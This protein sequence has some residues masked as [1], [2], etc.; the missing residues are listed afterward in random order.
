MKSRIKIV[1][2]MLLLS[3]MVVLAE[4]DTLEIHKTVSRVPRS[5]SKN[6]YVLANYL[7]KKYED[8]ESKSYAISNWIANNIKYDYKG[9]INH[10]TQQYSS[11]KVLKKRKA[12]CGEYS[13][14]YK[15]MCESVEIQAIT[16]SGYTK[17]LDFLAKDTIYISD[18]SWNIS[19]IND[20]L[21]L[22]DHTFAS[23]AIQPR[24]QLLKN[25][26]LGLVG[27]PYKPK[28]YFKQQFNPDWINVVPNKMILTHFPDLSM[29]QLLQN[30]V[31]VYDFS[32]EITIEESMPISDNLSIKNYIEM[33]F[34]IKMIYSA[35]KV[36]ETNQL[37]NKMAGYYY[38]MCVDYFFKNHY[39]S[40]TKTFDTSVDELLQ[41]NKYAFFADSLLK[42]TLI[43]NDANYQQKKLQNQQMRNVLKTNNKAF[44]DT[45][46]KR[47]RKNKENINISDKIQKKSKQIENYCKIQ[48]NKF[49][50]LKPLE[51]TKRP[52]SSKYTD[53]EKTNVFLSKLDSIQNK[54]I[55]AQLSKIDSLN[56]F[57]TDEKIA[58]NI[59]T[60]QLSTAT[61]PIIL[62]G[63]K[64]MEKQN[65]LGIPLMI[66]KYSFYLD[67]DDFINAVNSLDSLKMQYVDNM[68]PQLQENQNLFFEQIKQYTKSTTETINLLKT[69]K[70]KSTVQYNVDNYY[71][72]II[73]EYKS[74]LSEFAKYSDVYKT[75]QKDL[76]KNLKSQNKKIEKIISRLKNESKKENYR[77]KLYDDNLKNNRIREKNRVILFQNSLKK[78]RTEI[79]KG[80][81][82]NQKIN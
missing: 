36:K 61:Y 58:Q 59:L 66:H 23:G 22:T 1:F 68:M 64:K 13:N 29:F 32:Q 21:Q 69:I 8:N 65:A 75:S 11:E 3:N 12:L 2:I 76:V 5:K 18:H 47:I 7:T 48:N 43:D 6:Q 20:E 16:I 51:A 74:N 14:L 62:K 54:V 82:N 17:G 37:N 79:E 77:Y 70:K 33:P 19:L 41:I 35:Q 42:L 67:K 44:I 4:I 27:I 80:L 31:T 71:I 15:D 28:Y 45:L 72:E 78:Y 25:Y 73:A 34:Q 55:F 9:Y 46:Q 53:D 56:A 39:N 40:T 26:T 38:F 49:L 57:Y 24:K 30:P 81:K 50:S 63:L 60:E 52:T 10:R